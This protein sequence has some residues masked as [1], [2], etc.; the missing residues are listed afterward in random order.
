MRI[1][2][3]LIL[4]FMSAAVGTR[5][6][7]SECLA[8]GHNKRAHQTGYAGGTNA[9][10]ALRRGRTQSREQTVWWFYRL[11]A[12]EYHAMLEAGCG[13]CGSDLSART[14]DVDH[15]HR[16]DHPGKG[17]SSCRACVRGLLCRSCN[18]RVGAFERGLNHDPDIA[19][20]LSA[21][22]WLA[23]SVSQVQDSLF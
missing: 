13:L 5:L 14:P 17:S 1:Q 11:P 15:D 19:A 16:C 12:A 3:P 20:Y 23:T 6:R 8:P 10:P 4:N 22:D 18:L 7:C 21:R 2:L 9:P